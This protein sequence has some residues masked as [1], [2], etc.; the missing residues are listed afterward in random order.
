MTATT[1]PAQREARHLTWLRCNADQFDHAVTQEQ[2]AHGVLT[3]AG[4][5]PAMC[6][7]TITPG[8]MLESPGTTC[9]RCQSLVA[10]SD[11]VC[12]LGNQ[13]GGSVIGPWLTAVA[14]G[15]RRPRDNADV[16]SSDGRT[17][18]GES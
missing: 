6:G 14:D 1:L 10:E 8:S 9:P 17:A 18:C 12:H 13:R 3:G 4:H 16:P 15:A 2:L 11:H 5:F 7:H